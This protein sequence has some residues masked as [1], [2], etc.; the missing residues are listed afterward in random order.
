M[1]IYL[2]SNTITVQ[3]KYNKEWKLIN[4]YS[5]VDIL[6]NVNGYFIYSSYEWFSTIRLNGSFSHT[7][8]PDIHLSTLQRFHYFGADFNQPKMIIK[9]EKF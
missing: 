5:Y 6:P 7:N 4:C 2:Y 9:L 8:S 3:L 1:V